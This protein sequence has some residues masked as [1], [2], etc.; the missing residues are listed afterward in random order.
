MKPGVSGTSLSFGTFQSTDFRTVGGWIETGDDAFDYG[1]ILLS[2]PD[3]L[4]SLG[5][6]RFAEVIGNSI[7]GYVVNLAGYPGDKPDDTMWSD[8]RAVLAASN[9]HLHYEI[10]TAGGQSGAPVWVVDQN[11]RFVVGM[12][13]LGSPAVNS[14]LKINSAIFDRIV[15]WVT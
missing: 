11:Q 6:L 4:E 7:E 9:T 10:D 1:A 5:K 15:S 13:T 8:S 2:Q 12:H 3:A 14:A